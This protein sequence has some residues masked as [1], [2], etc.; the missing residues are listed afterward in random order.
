MTLPT[1]RAAITT[2][3]FLLLLCTISTAQNN[4][5][6]RHFSSDST[7]LSS[8]SAVYFDASGRITPFTKDQISITEDGIQSRIVSVTCTQPEAAKPVSS[9][10]TIDVS[11]S[12]Q[13]SR[14][15]RPV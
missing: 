10:L 15:P 9:V 8:A 12:R 14:R 13:V 3:A 4:L 6:L 5:F 7:G 2:I 11:G 1:T